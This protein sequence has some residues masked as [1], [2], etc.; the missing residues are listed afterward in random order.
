MTKTKNLPAVRKKNLPV[1]IVKYKDSKGNQ[2]E[3]NVGEPNGT[4]TIP[5]SDKLFST[6]DFITFCERNIATVKVVGK[7]D[8]VDGGVPTFEDALRLMGE[9]IPRAKIK[10][11]A[12][13][14]D[15]DARWTKLKNFIKSKA[16][17]GCTKKQMVDGTEIPLGAINQ[18]I[19]GHKDE[20]EDAGKS[21][22]E[23]K[24]RLR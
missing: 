16:M 24:F 13:K 23:K 1:Q 3:V 8:I 20:V 11:A 14:V 22:Q 7:D 12:G 19:A 17:A 2:W 5:G 21:G 18:L 15:H 10:T 4:F 9:P 6:K